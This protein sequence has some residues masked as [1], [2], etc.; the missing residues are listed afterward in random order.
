MH[1]LCSVER[2][3]LSCGRSSCGGKVQTLLLQQHCDPIVG[4]DCPCFHGAVLLYHQSRVTTSTYSA[5]G[6]R[7]VVER[8]LMQ[9]W[10]GPLVRCTA[11]QQFSLFDLG[12]HLVQSLLQHEI[13]S[14]QS[15]YYVPQP[16]L[17]AQRITTVGK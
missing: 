2:R 14:Q 1:W 16:L 11:A 9:S 13:A 4:G 15:V 6:Q 8:A 5:R 3:T 10:N 12:L 7:S 17:D